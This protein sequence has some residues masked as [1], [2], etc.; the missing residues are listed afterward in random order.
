MWPTTCGGSRRP[1]RPPTR[2][3]NRDPRPYVFYVDDVLEN[4]RDRERRP[5]PATGTAGQND[6]LRSRG[7]AKSAF[8][9]GRMDVQIRFI[10]SRR[11]H[12]LVAYNTIA[13]YGIKYCPCKGKTFGRYLRKRR[14]PEFPSS[15]LS[16]RQGGP[17]VLWA[18]RPGPLRIRTIRVVLAA[19][20]PCRLLYT[21]FRIIKS[22]LSIEYI[23]VTIVVPVLC[24][25]MYYVLRGCSRHKWAGRE[26]FW[27]FLS[28]WF[29]FFNPAFYRKYE[30]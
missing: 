26:V 15:P 30:V 2:P 8:R 5:P 4:G 19:D 10:K 21:S 3:A 22:R 29:P 28:C 7:T 12:W 6:G 20:Y 16:A 24:I 13:V 17:S 25:I 18:P 27:F 9:G 23:V 14:E 11:G 1:W